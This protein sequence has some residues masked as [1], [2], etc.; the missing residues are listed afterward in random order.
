MAA[1]HGYIKSQSSSRPERESRAGVQSRNEVQESSLRQR[2]PLRDLRP[3]ANIRR[4]TNGGASCPDC[5]GCRPEELKVCQDFSRFLFLASC[6]T[7]ESFQRG[8]TREEHERAIVPEL[9]GR[10]RFAT[11]LKKDLP[12]Q[13][14]HERTSDG[15]NNAVCLA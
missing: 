4:R 10:Y 15:G 12:A 13:N 11:F 1:E 9:R 3:E 2:Q 6:E 7:E 14:D 8:D 5:D